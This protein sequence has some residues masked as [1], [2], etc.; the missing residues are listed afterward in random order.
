MKYLCPQCESEE[1]TLAHV[2][3]FMA[4]TLDHYCHSTKTQDSDSPASCL[5]CDWSGRHDQLLN[6]KE[7][8]T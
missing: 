7:K 6:Y 1:V 4:N 5:D 3:L 2:Q 8:N